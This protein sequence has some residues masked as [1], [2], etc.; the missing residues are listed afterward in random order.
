MFKK[1]QAIFYRLLVIYPFCDEN[2]VGL[3]SVYVCIYVWT[4]A[5]W[6]TMRVLIAIGLDFTT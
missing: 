6:I 1:R 5:Y 2:K 3:T 4:G